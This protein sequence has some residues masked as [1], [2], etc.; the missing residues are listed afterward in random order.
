M[1]KRA[2]PEH[3]R[4]KKGQSGNPGGRPK[5]SKELAEIKTFND[6]ELKKVIS[7]YLR[8]SKPEL[9]KAGNSEDLPGIDLIIARTMVNAANKGDFSRIVYLIERVCGK[10]SEPEPNTIPVGIT[11]HLEGL[12]NQELITIAQ[13]A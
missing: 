6:M 7:K 5:C 10:V 8:M 9:I 2:P 3:S 13:S 12:S 1:T 4:F 11:M